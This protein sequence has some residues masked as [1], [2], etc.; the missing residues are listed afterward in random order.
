VTPRLIPRRRANR[1]SQGSLLP[2]PLLKTIQQGTLAYTYKGVPTLKNPFDWAL[3]PML[4]WEVQPRTVIEIGSNKG[5][6]AL[7]M[8]DLMR[9]FALPCHI[10]SVDIVPVTGVQAIGVTF[11]GGDARDLARVLGGDFMRGLARPLLVI[12]DADHRAVT[13][14]AVLR[15]FDSWLRPGEFI[16]VEDGILTEMGQAN[17]FGGGP[18]RAIEEFLAARGSDYAID[19]RYCDWFGRNVTWN[20][21]GF[22]RRT[23]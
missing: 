16:I 21:N 15:F 20:V 10:H 18:R 1:L 17:G 23:K 5:G 3:Y 12:E 9:A 2:R 7:W 4:F 8:A 14:L 19:T 11:H 13:T 6:S 22:L